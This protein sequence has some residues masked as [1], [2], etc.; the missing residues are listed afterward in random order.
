MVKTIKSRELQSALLSKG[1]EEAKEGK[2]KDHKY[3][4]LTLD[5][6]KYNIYTK[7]SHGMKEID[8]SL[9]K[10]IYKQ[11]EMPDLEYLKNYSHCTITKDEY[12]EMLRQSGVLL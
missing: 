1:F 3:Y 7:I 12:V 10:K 6:K 11:L 2:S 5:G 4:I 8:K 9:L